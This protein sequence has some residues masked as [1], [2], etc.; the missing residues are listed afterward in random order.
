MKAQSELAGDCKS[1]AEM[2]VPRALREV[3]IWNG[4][5]ESIDKLVSIPKFDITVEPYAEAAKSLER[6]LE[7]LMRPM[8]VI[9][10]PPT[11]ETL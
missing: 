8:E 10:S 6:T 2:T 11:A 7:T 4:I 1:A 5:T 9:H 3:T